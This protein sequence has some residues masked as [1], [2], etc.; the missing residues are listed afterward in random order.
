MKKQ[1]VKE[2]AD[3][4]EG[5]NATKLDE[6]KYWYWYFLAMASCEYLTILSI[7]FIK[8]NKSGMGMGLAVMYSKQ[9]KHV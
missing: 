2:L 7:I 9:Y 1:K 4:N 3:E 8:F 5:K 6:P